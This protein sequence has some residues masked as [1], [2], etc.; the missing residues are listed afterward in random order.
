MKLPVINSDGICV[1]EADQKVLNRIYKNLQNKNTDVLKIYNKEKSKRYKSLK[2]NILQ[3]DVDTK[4]PG[5]NAGNAL[6]SESSFS[7]AI[8]FTQPGQR[9]L[10][11]ISELVKQNGYDV[12]D[13]Y[14]KFGN[15]IVRDENG[16][17]ITYQA[18][19]SGRVGFVT[20][21]GLTLENGFI[22]IVNNMAVVESYLDAPATV[23]FD[24]EICL[25]F[26][27]D[28]IQMYV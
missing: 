26:K 24:V 25:D 27:S 22:N 16:N 23:Y 13:Y 17:N 2:L 12:F 4:A 28:F 1:G 9:L 20:E 7:G 19:E 14:A 3:M 11:D 5:Y 18:K 8:K 6:R 15:L 21:E 10:I